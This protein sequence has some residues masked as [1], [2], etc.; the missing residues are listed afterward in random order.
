MKK[1]KSASSLGSNGSPQ[2]QPSESA[3]LTESAGL[4]E[5][6]GS[7]ALQQDSLA[8]KESE[9][10]EIEPSS[11]KP[12]EE[13]LGSNGSPWGTPSRSAEAAGSAQSAGLAALQ[14]DSLAAKES[15]EME[16][17]PSS[18]QPL[19]EQPNQSE[20]AISSIPAIDKLRRFCFI[21]SIDEPVY[22]PP[23]LDLGVE[24]HFASL[25]KL[26]SQ[27]SQ[28]ELAEC[29]ESVLGSGPNAEHL[30]RPN[31]SLLI[32]AVFLSTCKDE[33]DRMLM[34][35]RVADLITHDSELLLFVQLVK[36]VQKVLERQ[37]PFNRTV[38]KAVLEWYDK[39]SLD[40]LLHLWSVGHETSWSAHRDLLRR[41]HFQ[42][43]YLS[44]EKIAA[45]R[46]LS[47]SP[48]QLFQW[49][50]FLTPLKNFRDIIKG[51]AKLRL[52]TDRGLAL[53]I[54]K[55]LSLSWEHVPLYFIHDTGLAKFLTPR[56]T[57]E[58]LLQSWP[59]VSRRHHHV[60][61][62]AEQLLDENKLKAGNVP[63]VRLLLEDML[64]KK[65][66]KV[67][68]ASV[69]KAS[70]LLSVYEISFGLNKALGKRLHITLNLE[71][72]YLGKYLTGRCRS[73]KYLD[74]LV[75]LAFGYFRSDPDVKVEFWYDHSGQLKT[76]PWTKEMSVSEAAACCE[77][78]KVDKVTQSLNSIVNRALL[79]EQ[80]TYDVFLVL[81]SGAARG[82]PGNNS[83]HLAALMDQYRE[84]RSSDAKFIMV[85]LRKQQRSMIYSS[86]RN[87]NLLELC[88]LDKHTPRL[89]NAFVHGK[90]Y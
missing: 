8:A 14:Q 89:I 22:A 82:N 71:K 86:A 85:S 84:K 79:D 26:C 20:T 73:L 25:N 32:L 23:A 75:A 67:S 87:E 41:C 7:S 81:V 69:K 36:R 28:P 70:F 66:K 64:Q 52:L 34:R 44:P 18:N 35:Y 57:Y 11:N 39:Q 51:V 68:S 59:R 3:G 30:P 78:Q 12:L 37:T 77:N 38:R 50:D 16:T 74:A 63:P 56:M 4:A 90:F 13:S 65:P 45:L 49:P 47:S 88:S 42:D 53:P 19:E 6:A 62:F 61:P 76:L 54:V 46:L 24:N 72:T 1:T 9:E 15:A 58:Q 2:G 10:M 5:S 31:E 60:R 29:L 80:N 55:K 17:E 21:G 33:M 48:K 83:E 27:V 40:R 43:V